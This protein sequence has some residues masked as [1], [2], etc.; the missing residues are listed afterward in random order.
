[1]CHGPSSK[2]VEA[3]KTVGRYQKASEAPPVNFKRISGDQYVRICA[4]CHLQSGMREPQS[5]G[6]VNYSGS[7][8]QFYR[9]LLSRPYV[10]FSRKAV[11]KDGRFRVTTFIVE[12][13]VRSQCFR[14]GQADCGSCHNPHPSQPGSNPV[15]LKFQDRPDEMCLQCH[16]DLRAKQASHT[17]HS[18]SSEGSRCVSCHMPRIMEAV[19]FPARSHQIDDIPDS[20]MTQRFGPQESPNACLVC[21]QNQRQAWLDGQLREWRR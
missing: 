2:H 5:D 10:D 7:G 16:S 1:M 3:M 18:L 19:L 15:S 8:S 14:K 13:F 21:H 6:L 4:Q 17:R 20:E 9:T 11:Y 12:S